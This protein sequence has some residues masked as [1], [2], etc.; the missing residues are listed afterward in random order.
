MGSDESFVGKKY[1]TE[2][3]TEAARCQFDHPGNIFNQDSVVRW[4][5]YGGMDEIKHEDGGR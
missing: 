1:Q 4:W 3:R 2:K 5:R